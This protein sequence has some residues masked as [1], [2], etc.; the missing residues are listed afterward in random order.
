M[1]RVYAKEG[2]VLIRA[3]RES[4][5]PLITEGFRLQ[6]WDKPAE[7]YR[8][9]FHEQQAG[10]RRVFVA[11]LGEAFAGYV[12]LLPE[13]AEGPFAGKGFPEICDF[14]VL[15]KYQRQG[16]GSLL[17]NAAEGV[18]AT[19]SGTVSLGVGL[20]AG[21]GAAQRMYVKRGYIPDGSGVW[22]RDAP[23]GPYM[24]CKNDDDLVLY[25]SKRLD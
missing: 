9:Y 25:L 20:H 23:L 12:T 17:L 8:R 1:D 11:F 18:A 15:I 21:Y 5:I 14:N 2:R 24:D 16:I 4:D 7:L 19:L 22:Y 13:K 10:K 3:I 6:G